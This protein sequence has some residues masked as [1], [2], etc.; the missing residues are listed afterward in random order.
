MSIVDDIPTN[1]ILGIRDD[2]GAAL[3]PVYLVTR[4]WSGGEPG[5]GTKADVVVQILPTPRVVE[6]KHDIR[7]LQGGL[8]QEGDVLLKG[9]SKETFPTED[10]VDGST[11][12]QNIEKF[13]RIGNTELYRVK[14]VVEKFVTWNVL[15]ER[16]NDT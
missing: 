12:A 11:S 14:S 9:I 1:D 7:I 2:I 4:T 5:D 3:K 15:T 13:Y 10:L 8:F 6:F 16:I